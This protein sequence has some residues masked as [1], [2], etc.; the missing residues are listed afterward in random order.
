MTAMLGGADRQVFR[1]ET[2]QADIP[3]KVGA[4]QSKLTLTRKVGRR[5]LLTGVA[6]TLLRSFQYSKLVAASL[7]K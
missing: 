3:Y 4:S 1:S 2:G 5:S 7:Q 6:P